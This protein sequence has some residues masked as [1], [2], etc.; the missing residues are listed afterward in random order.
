MLVA[1]HDD[2]NDPRYDIKQSD[3]E[4]PVTLELWGMRSISLLPSLPGLLCLGVV[5]PDRVLSMSQIDL[6]DI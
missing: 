6:F 4:A 2:D 5:T 3:S 1:R